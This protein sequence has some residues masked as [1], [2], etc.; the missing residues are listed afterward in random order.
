MYEYSIGVT[1]QT[2]LEAEWNCRTWGGSLTSI[3]SKAEQEHINS[4]LQKGES[5]L[6]GLDYLKSNL[7][8]NFTNWDKD[9]PMT[10]GAQH[11]TVLWPPTRRW[12]NVRCSAKHPYICK[13]DSGLVINYDDFEYKVSELQ[14]AWID[15]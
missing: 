7:T 11:C 1:E 4:L 10:A 14:M 3:E 2:A 8:V 12:R 6:I 15:A 5:Y 9:Q 13:R